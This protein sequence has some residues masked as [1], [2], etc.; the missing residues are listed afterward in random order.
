VILETSIAHGS[1]FVEWLDATGLDG[2]RR[3]I[4]PGTLTLRLAEAPADLRLD[5]RAALTALRRA[6][7]GLARVVP[8]APAPG[9]L[10]RPAAAPYALAGTVHDAA[11]RFLPRRFALTCGGGEGREVRLYRSPLGTPLRG[12]GL[13][14]A[15]AWAGGG[16]APWAVVRLRVTPPVGAALRFTA[17]ADAH[18]EF[19]LPLDVL[20]AP[21]RDAAAP[22]PARLEVLARRAAAAGEPLDPESLAPVAVASRKTGRRFTA[23]LTLDVAPGRAGVVTSPGEPCVLLDPG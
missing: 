6:A 13:R 21:V 3:P 10:E 9:D 20:P 2:V 1:D 23:S 16:A 5:H 4:A 18:G 14:G 7:G 22:Y 17:Q 15:L 12:G 19:V 11:R 8:G